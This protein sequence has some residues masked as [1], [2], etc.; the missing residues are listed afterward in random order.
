MNGRRKQTVIVVVM[1]VLGLL[2]LSYPFVSSWYNDRQLVDKVNTYQDEVDNIDPEYVKRELKKAQEYNDS[3]KG[4]P[5]KD[6]FV[7]GSGRALPENYMSVLNYNGLMGV[8]EI[9]KIN[10]NLPIQHGSSE[11][12][13]KRAIGHLEG[14]SLPI[15]SRGGHSMLTGHTGLPDATL[16]TNLTELQEGDKFYIKVLGRELIYEV[17]NIK[18]IIPEEFEK[19]E[20][21]GD[22]DFVTLVTCTP[23]GV[24]SHRL[25]VRG[26]RS[27]FM[28]KSI[29]VGNRHRLR[30]IVIFAVCILGV[31]VTTIKL[32]KD[33]K[34]RKIQQEKGE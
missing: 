12:V 20:L 25:L 23:Y 33:K 29:T 11:D 28:S 5:V 2:I 7:E 24:N 22:E 15:G 9:P 8:L 32:L 3:L 26:K 34:L 13:L 4:E 19:I 1:F 17:D 10:V 21:T 14:T 30:N 27:Y 18:I 6:P 16:L 31:I